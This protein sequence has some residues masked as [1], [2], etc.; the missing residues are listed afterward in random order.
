MV[1]IV[2]LCLTKVD[3]KP[4]MDYKDAAARGVP[5]SAL[6]FNAAVLVISGALTLEK[7]G[8]SD[9]LIQQ[10]HPPGLRD[11]PDHLHPGH[12]H[13]VHHRNQLLLQHRVRH[14][15]SIPSPPPSPWLWATSIW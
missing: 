10:R 13:P 2:I 5:W 3:G 12:R 14:R 6:I 11:E 1:A 9:F 7:V 8:I 4:I 15:C